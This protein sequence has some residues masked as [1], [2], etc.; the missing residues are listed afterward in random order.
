M[1]CPCCHAT[2]AI[3]PCNPIAYP[4]IDAYGDHALVCTHGNENREKYWHDAL[5]DLWASLARMTGIRTK[6]ENYRPL[7]QYGQTARRRTLSLGH[8]Y[9]GDPLRCDYL[10]QRPHVRHSQ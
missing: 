5:R 6:T 3:P 2:S 7:Q 1:Q 8:E 10:P 4:I 9:Q